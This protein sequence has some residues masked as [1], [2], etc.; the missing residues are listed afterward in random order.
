M[1][2]CLLDFLSLFENVAACR[3]FG[4]DDLATDFS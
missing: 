4:Y 1:P 2:V 3:A